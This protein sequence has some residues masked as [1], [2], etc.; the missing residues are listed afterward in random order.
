M[1]T[2]EMHI[3]IDLDLQRI[4]SQITKNILPQEKDWFLNREVHKFIEQRRKRKSN[5]KQIGFQDD[6]KRI[7]DLKSFIKTEALPIYQNNQGEKYSI[8]PSDYFEY[9]RFNAKVIKQCNQE[10]NTTEVSLNKIKLPL[11]INDIGILN[12]FT[13]SALI[14]AVSIPLFDITSLPSN[15]LVNEDFNKQKFLLIKALLIQ[16]DKVVKEKISPTST[17]YWENYGYETYPETFILISEVNI[18]SISITVNANTTINTPETVTYNSYDS[19]PLTSAIRVVDEEFKT[20][21]DNSSLSNSKANSLVSVLRKG[22]VIVSEPSSVIVGSLNIA[23]IC[24][25]TLID[26]Y[27]NSNL[28]ASR[29]VCEEIVSNTVRFIKGI[30]QDGDYQTYVRE[31]MLIE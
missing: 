29:K 30:I 26:L 11:N 5:I 22:V 1:T 27:L 15:Y 10:I 6:A 25:P 4:N 17:V 24:K 16:L 13:I 9:I 2:H 31:N 12:T 8:L 28:N 23:Y 20:H 14:N 3:G 21:I 18:T 19:L 7:E